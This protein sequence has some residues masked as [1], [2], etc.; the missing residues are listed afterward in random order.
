MTNLGHTAGSWKDGDSD[1]VRP[2]LKSGAFSSRQR[3]AN[4]E[5]P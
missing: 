1:T 3:G 2:M 5:V 4:W